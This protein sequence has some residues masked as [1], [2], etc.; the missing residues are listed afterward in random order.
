MYGKNSSALFKKSHQSHDSVSGVLCDLN[1]SCKGDKIS[2][3]S[4]KKGDTG[5]RLSKF[6]G[7][8]NSEFVMDD[9]KVMDFRTDL[10]HCLVDHG[11]PIPSDGCYRED[12]IEL[13]NNKNMD[14]CQAKKDFLE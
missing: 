8:W 11:F 12:V 13:I 14:E 5:S 7:I 2:I 6:E 3:D 4:F 9:N 10:P 1:G